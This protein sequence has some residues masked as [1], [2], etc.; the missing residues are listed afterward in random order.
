[1]YDRTKMKFYYQVSVR[2]YN[3]ISSFQQRREYY[4]ATFM[5]RIFCYYLS[6]LEPHLFMR[7]SQRF[8]T[9]VTLTEHREYSNSQNSLQQCVCCM[10]KDR[11]LYLFVYFW[12]R[13]Q[14]LLLKILNPGP[15]GGPQRVT[16]L[17]KFISKRLCVCVCVCRGINFSK[18]ETHLSL[19]PQSGFMT[20]PHKWRK[21]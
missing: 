9:W 1:M 7:G 13:G 2:I 11:W 10:Y 20:W 8:W 16:G 6:S 21:I 5:C 3:C 17:Q 12:R 18:E 14:L 15:K 4:T 19:K